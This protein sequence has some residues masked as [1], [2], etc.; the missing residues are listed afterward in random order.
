MS[1]GTEPLAGT[2]ENVDD[3]VRRLV[4]ER[5]HDLVVLCDLTGSIVYA[6]P[7]W[8]SVGW[9]PPALAGVAL[10]DLIHPDD[11]GVAAAAGESLNAG[12]NVDA[13]TVRLRRPDGA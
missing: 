10:Q 11:L 8:L 3:T 4:V 5:S 7:S 13:V 9:D 12:S 1:S 2:T 6:S